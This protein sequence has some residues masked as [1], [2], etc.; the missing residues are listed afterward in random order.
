MR[1]SYRR[2][3]FNHGGSKAV[4]LPKE[5]NKILGNKEIVVEV[6]EDGVFMYS[7]AFANLESDPNFHLFIEALIQDAMQNPDQLK[8]L[9][10][11]WDKEWDE[12]LKGVD[13]GSEI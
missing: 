1:T 4:N 3:L 6:R 7:D 11:V 2:R 12:L 5:A 9:E 10:D 8:N 13:G